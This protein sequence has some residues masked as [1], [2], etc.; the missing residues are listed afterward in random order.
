ETNTEN[1]NHKTSLSLFTKDSPKE[2]VKNTSSS[3]LLLTDK[4][5]NEQNK[6]TYRP[7]WLEYVLQIP[8]VPPISVDM[9]NKDNLMNAGNGQ[10][11]LSQDPFKERYRRSVPSQ[12]EEI[13]SQV[14]SGCPSVGRRIVID[15]C[16]VTMMVC[17]GLD[18]W[19][20]LGDTW[21]HGGT[22]SVTIK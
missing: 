10:M 8:K 3:S 19:L 6:A 21:F 13:Q 5:I 2:K 7:H 16:E 1:I 4:N 14:I 20:D 22:C 11:L 15:E 9:V 17:P 18:V 12:S